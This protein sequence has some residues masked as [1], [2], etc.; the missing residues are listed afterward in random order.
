MNAAGKPPERAA[1]TAWHPRPRA[2][3]ASRY[4]GQGRQPNTGHR[5]TDRTKLHFVQLI[6]CLAVFATALL[7]KTFSPESA[8]KI[9]TVFSQSIG[10]GLD[11]KAA[12]ASIGQTISNGGDVGEVLSV[13][14]SSLFGAPEKADNVTNLASPMPPSGMTAL[15]EPGAQGA[16]ISPGSETTRTED[17]QTDIS[18]QADGLQDDLPDNRAS[19]SL[20]SRGMTFPGWRNLDALTFDDALTLSGW[21]VNLSEEDALDDTPNVPFGLDVPANVDYSNILITFPHVTPVSGPMT[22]DF[23]YREHPVLGGNRFHYGLDIGAPSGTPIRC[24]AA[25]TV[26]YT[27]VSDSYG[28]YVKVNHADGISTFYAHC[29]AIL[30]KD[31]QTVKKNDVIAKVGMTGTATGPHLHLEVRCGETLLDPKHYVTCAETT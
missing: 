29:S 21:E 16:V 19:D 30:V 20:S 24:F 1:T 14:S 11:Y 17:N 18:V 22:S 23:G 9:K 5:K 4:P 28:K 25:G 6:V 31:G 2:A 26:E 15:P 7:I 13:I 10:G 27:G 3:N 8:D 12:F